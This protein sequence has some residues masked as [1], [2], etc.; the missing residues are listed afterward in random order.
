MLKMPSLAWIALA[1]N[2]GVKPPPPRQSLASVQLEDIVLGEK[3]GEV[4]VLGCAGVRVNKMTQTHI[5]VFSGDVVNREKGAVAG[6]N[7][8]GQAV[9]D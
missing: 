6:E 3:L 1:G 5:V 4:R 8:C 2:P 9:Q 7:S